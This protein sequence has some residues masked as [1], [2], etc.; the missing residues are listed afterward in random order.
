MTIFKNSTSI[1]MLGRFFSSTAV[2]TQYWAVSKKHDNIT[3]HIWGTS[4]L[5]EGK[6]SSVAHMQNSDNRR[7]SSNIVV[8]FTYC[9]YSPTT[10]NKESIVKLRFRDTTQKLHEEKY[11]VDAVQYW[12]EWNK[13]DIT[14]YWH[15]STSTDKGLNMTWNIYTFGSHIQ[16]YFSSQHSSDSEVQVYPYC[17]E[18]ATKPLILST[19]L[20]S[21]GEY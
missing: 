1:W 12:G 19:F 17:P 11:C 7:S 18:C 4:W 21:W 5:Q 10:Q 20:L 6:M 9:L 14:R 16:Y 3:G 15:N 13:E 2:A 8:S